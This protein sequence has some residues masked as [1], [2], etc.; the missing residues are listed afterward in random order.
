[1]S[2]APPFADDDDIDA[3]ADVAS[4]RPTAAERCRSRT[5]ETVRMG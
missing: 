3:Q 5:D 2:I 1:M 4:R